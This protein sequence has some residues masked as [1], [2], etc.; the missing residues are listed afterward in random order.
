MTR[1]PPKFWRTRQER[2]PDREPA[3]ANVL[4]GKVRTGALFAPAVQTLK[5]ALRS[6]AG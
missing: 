4:M 1:K 6:A 5:H 2:V 3:V